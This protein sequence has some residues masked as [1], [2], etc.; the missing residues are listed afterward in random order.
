MDGE[1]NFITDKQLFSIAT[2]SCRERRFNDAFVAYLE[3]ARRGYKNCQVFV[4][5]MYYEGKGTSH[6]DQAALT[7]FKKAADSGSAEGMF[8]SARLLDKQ[9]LHE[10]AVAYLRSA[11]DQGYAPALC[12]LGRMYLSGRG[13]DT[14]AEVAYKLL[15]RAA[16]MGNVFAKRELAAR[17]FRTSKSALHRIFGAGY[18]ICCVFQGM[19]I[20]LIDSRSEKIRS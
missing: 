1:S 11:S 7:W 5:W 13:V 14:N 12:R 8:Y 4:G 18:F 20:A 3:L 9:G 15:E 2:Q 16:T 10:E 6:D 19:C 17:M